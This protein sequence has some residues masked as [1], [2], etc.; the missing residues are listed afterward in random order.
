MRYL[1]LP[2]TKILLFLCEWFDASHRGAKVDH[3]FNIIEVKNTRKYRNYDPF[4]TLREMSNKCIT[5]SIH[6]VETKLTGG[7]L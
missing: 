7:S 1:N 5:L 4:I 3:N 2:K 6:C